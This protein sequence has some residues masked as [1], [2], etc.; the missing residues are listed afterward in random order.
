[1]HHANVGARRLGEGTLYPVG[2]PSTKNGVQRLRYQSNRAHCTA[3]VLR[4]QCLP[5]KTPV[6]QL[7]RSDYAESTERHR[8]CQCQCQRMDTPEAKARTRRRSGLSE[9]P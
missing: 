8:Q 4:E 1:M 2:K 6:R 5:E 9:H 3:C 7:Y